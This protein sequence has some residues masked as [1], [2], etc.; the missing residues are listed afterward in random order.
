M[1]ELDYVK[2]PRSHLETWER[3]K[4]IIIWSC[5]LIAITL[6]IMAATLTG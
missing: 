6:L 5:A 3:L 2:A 1:Q 4:K